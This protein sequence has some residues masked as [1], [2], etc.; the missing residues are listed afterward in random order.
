MTHRPEFFCILRVL[1]GRFSLR[2]HDLSCDL[3]KLIKVQPDEK[4]VSIHGDITLMHSM[5]YVVY[6]NIH[7]HYQTENYDL[8]SDRIVS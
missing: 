1:F 2:K 3:G 7:Q 4:R 8:P 6:I 5:L